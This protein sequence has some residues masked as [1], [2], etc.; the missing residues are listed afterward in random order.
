[1]GDQGQKTF[2]FATLRLTSGS[3]RAVLTRR[4]AR[5]LHVHRADAK[6]PADADLDDGRRA[7]NATY[8]DGVRVLDRYP[9]AAST[10][11]GPDHEPAQ[12]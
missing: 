8:F 2:T 11:A 7:H 9:M 1:V 6:F 12:P 10:T 5:H 4:S 3:P